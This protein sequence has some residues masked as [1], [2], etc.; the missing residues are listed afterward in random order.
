M[1][2]I[3]AVMV[4]YLSYLTEENKLPVGE[5]MDVPLLILPWLSGGKS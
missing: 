3:W 4:Y 1:H 5:L 2:F